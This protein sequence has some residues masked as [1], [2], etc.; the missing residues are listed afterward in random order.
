AAGRVA[1]SGAAGAK[2]AYGIAWRPYSSA[3]LAELRAAR[4]PV[5]VD[6]TAAWCLTCKVNEHVVFSSRDV[7]DA[8]AARDVAMLRAD[9]TSRDDEITRALASFGRSGVPLYVLY[10]SGA[11]PVVLPSVLTR[12]MILDALQKIG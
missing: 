6:F 10:G 7:R 2:G 3:A 1:A 4:T 8:F 5:F 9:W 12:G 11:E